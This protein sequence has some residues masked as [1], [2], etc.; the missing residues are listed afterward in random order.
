M[1]IPGELIGKTAVVTGSSRGIGRALILGLAKAGAQVAVHATQPSARAEAVSEEC[2]ALGVKTCVLYGDLGEKETPS[3][4]LKECAERLGS[5]DILV[6]N[7]S[8]QYRRA[9]DDWND[10]EV[11]SLLNV[12]LRA[13]AEM[14][15]RAL[16]AM[17]QAGWGRVISIGSVQQD[18]PNPAMML[19]AATKC[20]QLSLI[21]T[22]AAQV[23][24]DGITMNHLAPGVI[25]TDRNIE[26]L[27]DEGYREKIARK[28]PSRRFGV[29]E[30]FVGAMLLLCSQAGRYITGA[31]IPI[32]GG[33]AIM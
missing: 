28:I 31:D 6:L 10:Q 30:H 27:S 5:V 1:E 3:R 21:K 24:A 14:M 23:A 25:E 29:P 18:V 20:A 22:L 32:D 33:M 15:V 4:L 7:A 19:Y 2:R 11:D 12:N 17:Q 8:V 9:W 13:S 26:A 16:P